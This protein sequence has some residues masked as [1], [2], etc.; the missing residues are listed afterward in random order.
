MAV[1]VNTSLKAAQGNV[2]ARLPQMHTILPNDRNIL[3]FYPPI[4]YYTLQ[5]TSANALFI[6]NIRFAQ[7]F[8]SQS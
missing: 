1:S 8:S 3:H 6:C 2:D 4:S 5:R 7:I